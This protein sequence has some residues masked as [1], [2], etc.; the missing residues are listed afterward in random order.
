MNEIRNNL[1]NFLKYKDLLF[2]LVAKDIKI[3]Y[4]RS[5]LGILWSLLNPLLT[6]AI[7]TLVFREL[8]RFNIE[9]FAAYVISGQV[10]FSFFSESTSLAMSSI[11]SSGQIIK[12]VYIPKYIFPLSKVLYSLANM[13]F[14]FVAVII[15]CIATGV[16]LHFT[17]I[18]SF[19]SIIY[20]AIFSVGAGLILS[21]VV[22]FFRDIEHIYGVF[23]AAWM[24]ATPIIYP[25][26]IMPDKYMFLFYCNPMYYFVTHFREGLLYGNA[27]VFELNVQCLIYSLGTFII[28]LYVFRKNQDRFIL[29]I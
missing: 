20:V 19:L 13:M 24:Y 6:M 16:E 25:M 11:Y 2:L 4:K 12:K 26:N 22:V 8:F 17:V 21:S 15:V 9:Y 23:I 1:L 29:Y 18:Y 10:L 14:S 5:F 27:P 28:G 3:K 7:L